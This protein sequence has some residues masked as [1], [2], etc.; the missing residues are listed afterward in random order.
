M[1]K[2]Q[3]IIIIRHGESVGNID[4]TIYRT[5]PDY[6]VPL[7][8]KGRIQAAD[9][10]VQLRQK[11]GSAKV[12]AYVSPFFR[13]RET[14]DRINAAFEP[15]QIQYQEAI[16]IREQEWRTDFGDFDMAEEK[17]RL[18][19]SLFYYKFKGGE[20]CAQCYDRCGLFIDKLY[21]DFEQPDYPENCFIVSH[22]MLMRVL[23]MRWMN[24]TP[25]QFES[26]QNPRN[27]GTYTLLLKADGSYGLSS[28]P[29]RHP[30]PSHPFQ[31]KKP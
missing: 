22:G 24:W 12:R 16:Q 30:A 18:N 17:A 28:E 11:I 1:P 14:F 15:D 7:T 26:L 3:Q 21:K 19:Y 29:E 13:T 6:A 8:L 10:G 25:E 9:K 20:N 27:C 2:P 4:K 23:L 5:V 31:Y